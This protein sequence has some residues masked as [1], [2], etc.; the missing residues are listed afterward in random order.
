VLASE[1]ERMEKPP[2]DSTVAYEHYLRALSLP[3]IAVFPEFRSEYMESLDRAIVADP[4]FSEA[5]ALRAIGYIESSELNAALEDARTALELDPMNGAAHSALGNIYGYYYDRQ[6]EARDAHELAVELSPNDPKVLIT[7][8]RFLAFHYEEYEEAIRLGE[9]AIT[10]DPRDFTLHDRLGHVYL[11]AADFPA[12][13]ISA[14]EAISV[15]PGAAAPYWTL[16]ASEFL[17]GDTA[18]A[19]DHL[20]TGERI[21]Q[22]APV[23]GLAYMAYL[24]GLLGEH[25]QAARLV[26]RFDDPT[27][28]LARDRAYLPYAILG[29]GDTERARQEWND[30]IDGYLE[31]GLPAGESVIY[32]FRTNELRDPVLSQP[33]FIELRRRLGFRE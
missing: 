23:W 3:H 33:E 28:L 11:A 22:P 15:E 29:T 2:T 32:G 8:A 4:E 27:E 21:W 10:I 14:R 9:R 30:L 6:D 18:A 1:H 31:E 13:A 7:Y 26:A 20:N 25:D 24:Y 12:A 17:I 5:Y 19:R 16:A